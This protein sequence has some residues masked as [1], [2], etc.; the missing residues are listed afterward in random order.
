MRGQAKKIIID[1]NENGDCTIEGKGFVGPECESLIKEVEQALGKRISAT[2]KPS[3]SR[4]QT[5]RGQNVQRH[6]R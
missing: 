1:I 4:R 3:H 2:N 5:I 6:S